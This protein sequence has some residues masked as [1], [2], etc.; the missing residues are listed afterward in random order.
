MTASNGIVVRQSS[1][2]WA[3]HSS[4]RVVQSVTCVS[5]CDREASDHEDALAH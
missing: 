5:Q 2:C 3:D 4:W 1:V